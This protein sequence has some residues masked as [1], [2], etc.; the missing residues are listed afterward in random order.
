MPMQLMDSSFMR[1]DYA[2][3]AGGTEVCMLIL[4]DYLWT[5]DL[6]SATKFL[7]I[8]FKT[9]EFFMAH[10]PVRSGKVAFFPS[11][12]L[13]SYQ[14]AERLI[15][16]SWVDL[17]QQMNLSW[18]P[19]DR[20]WH[21]GLN[22]SN[23]VLN[24]APTVAA[25][26]SLT[27]R[28]LALPAELVTQQQRSAWQAYANALPELPRSPDNST[29]TV[30]ENIAEFPMNVSNSETPQL[31]AVHPFRLFTAARAN[32]S[33]VDLSPA[34][35]AATGGQPGFG[36]DGGWAQDLMNDALLGR[37]LEASA[38][39]INRAMHSGCQTPK[40]ATIFGWYE[41]CSPNQTQAAPG[42]R[43]KGY[44]YQSGLSAHPP[45]VEQLSN[46]QTALNFML[47]QPA[48]DGFDGGIIMFPAWPCDW[49]VDAELAA[50]GNA[51]V[52]V[53]YVAGKLVSLVVEP[54]ER[55][56]KVS[57]LNCVSGPV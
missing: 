47:M 7:P 14:C 53:R 1:F 9:L 41:R 45:A 26:T 31:Y 55:A 39:V 44:G 11:Q 50:P 13:E 57:F 43:F 17:T 40:G 24:D 16:G 6:A 37:S 8:C 32:A 36:Q 49:S 28:L 54:P 2:G 25:L 3:N 52:H 46:M 30:Y 33:G 34:L 21:G 27:R 5:R 35:K 15:N 12:A 38:L 42:Y 23:C 10:Y 20:Q 4:D 22:T 19:S 56:S 29:L 51:T 18:S 48:D